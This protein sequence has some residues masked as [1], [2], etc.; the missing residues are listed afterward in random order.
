MKAK[1]NLVYV[2]QSDQGEGSHYSESAQ[3]QPRTCG[4]S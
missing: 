2:Q 3:L 4:L 1:I